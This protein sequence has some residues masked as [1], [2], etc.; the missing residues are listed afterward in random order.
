MSIERDLN[1][2]CQMAIKFGASDAKPIKAEDVIVKDWVRLKCQYGCGG[3][4]KRLT[5]PPYSPRPEEFR[6]VLREYDWAS[7][8]Q[9]ER[10]R[11]QLE[12]PT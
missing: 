10:A 4:G 12:E 6:K 9:A 8:V 11:V 2:F 7:E 5:C 3:Y 1:R